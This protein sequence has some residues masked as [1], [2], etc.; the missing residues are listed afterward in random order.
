VLVV[1]ECVFGIVLVGG[2]FGLFGLD[3]NVELEKI[4]G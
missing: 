4:W 3:G 2:V 1:D